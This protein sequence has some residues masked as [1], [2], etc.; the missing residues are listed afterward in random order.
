M[1][2][3]EDQLH[4]STV[5]QACTVKPDNQLTWVFLISLPTR[6]GSP[7]LPTVSSGAGL[8]CIYQSINL[9]CKDKMHSCYGGESCADDVA[10]GGGCRCTLSP[11]GGTSRRFKDGLQ[12][13]RGVG[14]VYSISRRPD[15]IYFAAGQPGMST[16]SFTEQL[17]LEAFRMSCGLFALMLLCRS[18]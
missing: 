15:V 1:Q 11:H 13:R 16:V 5:T 9:L 14:W 3:M 18:L 8:V 4:L 10:L 7:W 17:F 6:G 12:Q 2:L